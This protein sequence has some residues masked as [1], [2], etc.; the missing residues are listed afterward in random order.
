MRLLR[1]DAKQAAAADPVCE[2]RI[3]DD[4]HVERSRP[5]PK[6]RCPEWD[7]QFSFPVPDPTTA[8]LTLDVFVRVFVVDSLLSK[9]SGTRSSSGAAR[10]S[11][12][13]STNKYVRVPVGTLTVPLAECLWTP[14]T[15]QPFPPAKWYDLNVWGRTGKDVKD[16]GSGAGGVGE[17]G[18]SGGRVRMQLVL[19]QAPPKV[20]PGK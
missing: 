20:G 4:A 2:L 18:G 15:G 9:A 11:G 19:I 12:T 16:A 10:A 13:W 8:T 3:N 14:G 7:A 6:G 5:A 17:G 1:I